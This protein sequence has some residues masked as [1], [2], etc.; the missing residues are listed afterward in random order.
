MYLYYVFIVRGE[1][2]ETPQKRKCIDDNTISHKKSK[3][4]V[5]ENMI[6][7]ASTSKNCNYSSFLKI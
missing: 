2:S 7:T 4:I 3:S 5:D 1:I 6:I